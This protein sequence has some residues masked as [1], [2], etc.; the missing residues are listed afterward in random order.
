[1]K[2]KKNEEK[3]SGGDG[4]CKPE[5]RKIINNKTDLVRADLMRFPKET[6]F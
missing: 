3:E 2:R 4:R 1:M 6:Y 5:S